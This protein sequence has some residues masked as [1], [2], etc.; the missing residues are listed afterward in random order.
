MNRLTLHKNIVQKFRE[1]YLATVS[2]IIEHASPISLAQRWNVLFQ[3]SI[4]P[5]PEWIAPDF[6][7][8]ML[9]MYQVPSYENLLPRYFGNEECWGAIVSPRVATTTGEPIAF[10]EHWFVSDPGDLEQITEAVKKL[11]PFPYAAIW[12]PITPGHRCA[13]M[14]KGLESGCLKEC[15]Y[16]ADWDRSR[17]EVRSVTKFSQFSCSTNQDLDS[18]WPDFCQVLSRGGTA[19]IPEFGIAS[20][21]KTMEA[22]PQNGGIVTLQ[23]DQGLAAHVSWYKGSDAEL[24]IPQCWNIPYIFVRDDLRGQGLAKYV[25]ALA[26]QNMAFDEIPLVCA[27]AQADNQPS[28]K[29]LETVGAER[30]LEYYTVA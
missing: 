17:P 29:A 19:P 21:R 22:C 27:R 5:Q 3:C 7:M 6:L 16:V 24:L 12:I 9:D 8:A 26:S 25:Y 11:W 28:I 30:V 20:L 2:P 4:A 13:S 14:I 15:A 18:W 23:D 10:I 1:E